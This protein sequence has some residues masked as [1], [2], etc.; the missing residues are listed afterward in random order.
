MRLPETGVFYPPTLITGVI[1]CYNNV[2]SY[3]YSQVYQ[4]CVR[5]PETGVFYP[6]TLITGVQTVSAVVTEEVRTVNLL[7]YF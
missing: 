3:Y 6:P 1:I 7:V 5:L 2:N 4:A